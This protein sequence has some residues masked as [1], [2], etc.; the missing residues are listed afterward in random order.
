M[1]QTESENPQ[2]EGEAEEETVYLQPNLK[3]WGRGPVVKTERRSEG[4]VKAAITQEVT[5]EM[6][7]L[8]PT[9]EALWDVIDLDKRSPSS[10]KY[11][12]APQAAWEWLL[13]SRG[14]DDLERPRGHEYEVEVRGSVKTYLQ[15]AQVAEE[16]DVK[17]MSGSR[18]LGILE[19]KGV[20]CDS[21]TL[22]RAELATD[23]EERK[24]ILTKLTE[25]EDE[26]D[27]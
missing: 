7:C 9:V 21:L 2:A 26:N 20:F 16:S 17:A 6:E 5:V 11:P 24:E 19:E 8:L 13:D 23:A 18:L 10:E 1:S 27:S 22:A 12:K 15:L 3:V 4:S 25:E 14:Y